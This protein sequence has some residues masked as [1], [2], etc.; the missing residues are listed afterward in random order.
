MKSVRDNFFSASEFEQM[1]MQYF[2]YPN[3]AMNEYEKWKKERMEYYIKL[4]IP[5]SNF[6]SKIMRIWFL[7]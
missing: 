7:C 1:E 4:G 5:K 3:E 2:V 6:V